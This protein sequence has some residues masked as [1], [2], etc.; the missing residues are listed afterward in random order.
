M[1]IG[2]TY[3]LKSDSH[4]SSI[5]RIPEDAAEEFDQPE[6]IEAL[7]KVLSSGGD[8]VFPLGGDLGILG[9]IKDRSIE[10]VF[11]IAEGFQ[12][13]SREAHIPAL[14]ELMGIPYSG[15]DPLALALTLDKAL[16]K[17]IAFSL[18]IPTPQFWVLDGTGD[19]QSVT[20]RFPLFVKPAWQ[21]S[22][23]GIWLSSRVGD[24]TQLEKEVNRLFEDYPE[25]PVLVEEYIPGREI[26][27][28]VLGSPPEI[29]GLMEIA[30]QDPVQKDFC[31]SLEVKQDWKK[32][33]AYHFP[34][35]LA[36]SLQ[37]RICDSALRL[38]K[39]LRLRDVA[40]FDFRV[41]PEGKFY[42]LEVNPLPGLSPES[43]D[44]VILAQKKGWSYR[45]LI[46]KITHSALSRYPGLGLG[47]Q[48]GKMIAAR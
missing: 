48:K 7:Q 38:F 18:E 4:P 17:R 16:T 2:I 29:V 27:V 36:E 32:Q 21:G 45:D 39:A 14:L 28:G 13:R 10:F 30:F 26:T 40:R 46:L 42:F 20:G 11:N 15:S 8:E 43:G 12:G 3:N 6:T 19:L 31:Y 22:S 25:E 23:K 9:K 47:N 5:S 44:L 35:R 34:A 24:R 1:R 33:A 37:Q 41:S